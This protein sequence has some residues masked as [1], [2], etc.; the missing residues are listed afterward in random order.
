M[1]I[2]VY[3]TVAVFF[4]KK[5]KKSKAAGFANMFFLG[6]AIFFTALFS[7]QIAL[8]GDALWGYLEPTATN[9][10]RGQF[11]GHDIPEN[12]DKILFLYNTVQ[13]LYIIG[14]SALL[15]LQAAQIYPLEKTVNW[16]RAIGTK[17]L[18]VIA[19]GLWLVFIPALTWTYL[20]FAL[21]FGTILGIV[22]GLV[23]NVGV[24]IKLAVMTTGDLRKRSLAIIFAS[25]LFYFGF[26]I[27]LE[28]QEL[29]ITGDGKLDIV[30]GCIIQTLSAIL[31]WR[32]LRTGD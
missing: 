21:L 5:Y 24:N 12:Q 16:E 18:V 10:L 8:A 23:I 19:V 29:S 20:T 1:L 3:L 14:L 6:Y 31:Y 9:W 13:P 30:L 26:I 32:G 22:Y 17:T 15:L 28:I 25:I 11:P 2:F 4:I 27:T 7:V